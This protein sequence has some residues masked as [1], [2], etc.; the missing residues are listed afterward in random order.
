MIFFFHQSSFPI[1]V[2][3][4]CHINLTL[5]NAVIS[6][7]TYPTPKDRLTDLNSAEK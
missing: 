5:M 3:F 4:Q 2:K 6:L 1:I 7:R